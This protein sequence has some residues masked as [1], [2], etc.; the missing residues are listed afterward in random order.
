MTW[1]FY[2]L[3]RHP[4][5]LRKV[6]D[7]SMA[8][9]P[10]VLPSANLPLSFDHVHQPSLPYALAV[11]NETLRLYPPVPVE[12][13]ECIASSSFPDGTLLPI[14]AVVIWVPWAMGRSKQIWGEDADIFRPQRWF[15]E[16]STDRLKTISAFE[17]PVFNGGPRSCL[18]KKMAELL[19]VYVIASL[20][21]NYDFEEIFSS[22]RARKI[23]SARESQNSLT[24]PM[25]GG[26]PCYVRKRGL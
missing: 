22:E 26:L 8:K 24:L 16:G 17:F 19:A 10:G 7:E 5:V 1:A 21:W 4:N 2:L 6:R 12:L 18:G 3:M 23:H 13:K 14:G 11:F 20:A 9:F 15:E 25:D